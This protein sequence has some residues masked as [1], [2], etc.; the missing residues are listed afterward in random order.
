MP[1]RTASRDQAV[2]TPLDRSTTLTRELVHRDALSEVL[3]SDLTTTET[4]FL[5]AVQWPRRHHY[6][7]TNLGA[8]D[9]TLV[10]ETLRQV[11]IAVAHVGFDVPAAHRF[12]MDRIQLVR[13]AR[14]ADELA[15]DGLVTADVTVVSAR[16]ARG[17][18]QALQLLV[19]FAAGATL[20]ASGE[21]WLRVLPDEVYQ[22]VRAA[23]PRSIAIEAD[24][25]AWSGRRAP[26]FARGVRLRRVDAGAW[27]VDV[28]LS[29]PVL[30]D[31]RLDHLPGM[32]VVEA[33]ELALAELV[34]APALTLDAFD[35]TY[36]G[37]LELADGLQIRLRE[38]EP[39]GRGSA[40]F[41]LLQGGVAQVTASVSARIPS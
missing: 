10:A 24:R 23:A 41:E 16:M 5:A 32:L 19:R 40:V 29:H 8:V 39:A 17:R 31:H 35:G 18:L 6:F 33:C 34:A 36:R 28:D 14:R 30:F 1:T 2:R 38:R 26:Q 15:V 3:L 27:D 20:L 4:G 25:E 37:F 9:V 13:L 21:G 22:R 11:T 12:L 7:R